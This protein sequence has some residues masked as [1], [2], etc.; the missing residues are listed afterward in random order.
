[1]EHI[2]DQLNQLKTSL[3]TL[4]RTI[5]ESVEEVNFQ[6]D[7]VSH[8]L[9]EYTHD[10]KMESIGLMA[11]GVAHD[12]KN[13]LHVIGVNAE[14]IRSCAADEKTNRRAGQIVDVCHKTSDLVRHM[15]EIA[16][17]D[18]RPTQPV[19]FNG[20]VRSGIIMLKSALPEGI[21]LQTDYADHL[22]RINGDAT[23]ICQ[24]VTNLVKNAAEAMEADGRILV[25]T[26]AEDLR[27]ADCVL[28]GNARPGRFAVLRVMDDGPGIPRD[29]LPRIYDPFFS[30]KNRGGNSGFGLAIVYTIARRH[31]GW[32]DVKSQRGRGTQFSVFFPISEYEST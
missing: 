12:F 29:V 9:A 4:S 32:I 10:R 5:N 2:R 13:F 22:P 17:T 21:R 15:M 31:G 30:T 7:S 19:D 23:Q 11:G 6:M 18:E 26:R 28:H 3:K 27:P 24:V 20:E 8:I 1:M 25:S 16:K 14:L